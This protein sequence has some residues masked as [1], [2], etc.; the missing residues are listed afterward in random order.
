MTNQEIAAAFNQ[1]GELLEL[2]G[3]NV[4]RVRA[5][6]RAS[7]MI[8]S[9]PDSLATIAREGGAK[10]LKE[11]PGIGEDLAAKIVEMT[12]T[13]GLT[14]FDE[15]KEQVPAGLIEL[16]KFEGLGPKKVLKLWQDFE[17]TDTAG[18][19]KFLASGKLEEEKG[20][21]PKSVENLKRSILERTNLAAR[22]PL[23]QA[24]PLAE[25]VAGSLRQSGLCER[26]EIAGSARRRK[27][28]VG[29]LD[30]LATGKDVEKI[31]D[32]F[33]GLPQVERVMQ[34][35]D[36]KASV[37]LA[38]GLQADLR[39]V[40]DAVFGAALHYFT[41]SKEHNVALRTLAQKKGVTINEYGVHKGTA[42]KKGKLLAS[43]T[44]ADVYA[45]LKM[46]EVPPELRENRGEVELALAHDLPRLI[47]E[48][49]L[50]GDLHTHSDVSDGALPLEEMAAAARDRGYEYY[51]I[52]DHASAMGMV[53]GIKADTVADF[54][55]R[56]R[57]AEKK[58]KGIRLLAG[59]EVD[60][61]EDGR[62]YLPDD[63]LALLDWVVASPHQH[64]RQEP[65]AATARLVKAVSHPLVDMIGHPS[66][67]VLGKRGGLEPDWTQIF[68]AAAKHGTAMELNCSP[69][70]VD[71]SDALAY[72]AKRAGVGILLDSDAHSP[73]GFDRR[74]G[75]FQARR[76][77]LTPA[78][79]LNALPWEKFEKQVLRTK[80]KA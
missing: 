60:I 2:T 12:E 28:T 26:V 58:V 29:D 30:F 63:A 53:R 61:L 59:A 35:G 23:F 50:K 5:Y 37:R 16:L 74:Y 62:L 54:V 51:A 34:R 3:A 38:L 72:Q 57:A 22:I 71:L 20:W 55:A 39:V 11:L 18:L 1:I 69:D 78:D 73:D 19:E 56:V 77:W 42:D 52:T 64:L 66:G 9:L 32:L 21:G 27:E 45:V 4:F 70:R 25:S 17:V 15:L 10:A 40:D 41:G 46:D 67:R 44:E 75:I 80:K 47:E 31:M 68:A 33:C 6:A 14:Y 24:L 79:V 8:E 48:S 76:A 7:Q 13:G 36:T 65:A 43:R 49:D